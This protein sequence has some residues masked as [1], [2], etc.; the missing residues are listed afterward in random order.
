MQCDSYGL[1]TKRIVAVLFSADSAAHAQSGDF[2]SIY[3]GG[4]GTG[5]Y[6][7]RSSPELLRGDFRAIRKRKDDTIEFDRL[8]RYCSTGFTF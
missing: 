5:Q 7:S 4:A 6:Q 3:S 1:D 2:L 8:H